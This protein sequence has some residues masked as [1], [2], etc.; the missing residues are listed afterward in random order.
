MKIRNNITILINEYWLR[1]ITKYEQYYNLSLVSYKFLI[2][3]LSLTITLI[4]LGTFFA[5]KSQGGGAT[6]LPESVRGA[7][8]PPAPPVSAPV[9]ALQSIKSPA[10]NSLFMA[11]LWLGKNKQ[12]II[13]AGNRAYKKTGSLNS[14]KS[15]LTA[16]PLWVTLY[17]MKKV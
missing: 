4:K 13:V 1:N 11:L 5:S 8:I 9:I 10:L 7:N 17:L 2:L 6:P 12:V 16:H 15:S 14:V 3:N